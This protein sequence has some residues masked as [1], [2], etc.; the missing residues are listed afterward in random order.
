MESRAVRPQ[1]PDYLLVERLHAG[2]FVLQR[3]R[4]PTLRS[5]MTYVAHSRIAPI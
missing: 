4:E 5:L 3:A 1:Y 2:E